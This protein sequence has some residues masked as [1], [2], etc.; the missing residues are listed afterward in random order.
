MRT[1]RGLSKAL[2]EE[3]PVLRSCHGLV[4]ALALVLSIAPCLSAQ[5]NP[6]WTEQK[7]EGYLPHMTV[8]EVQDLLT[9]TD[10]VIIPVASLE[11][12]GRHLP[13]GTDFL[14]GLERAKLIAARTDVLVAPILFP[15]QSPYHMGF[16]GTITLSAETVQRVYVEAAESLIRHGF[17]RL[18]FLNAHGGNQAITRFIVDRINQE[19]AGIAVELGAASAPFRPRTAATAPEEPRVF[20]RHGGVSET[21]RGLYLFPNLVDLASAR[22]AVL[23]LPRH[24]ERML[25]E[26]VAGDPAA[27]LVF[28]A[29]GLKAEETGKGTSAKEMST[30]GV[31]GVRDPREATAE[32]G[33]RETEA[34][35]EAA[36]RF[37]ERWKELRPMER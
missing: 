9:R 14:S 22:P 8:P 12:H 30:T 11:Q 31:W 24:M 32:Q 28:L 15:G 10:M 26:V 4:A 23:T 19:T 13:I 35:V 36:V 21:S 29:E 18:L 7:F 16:E 33:Q 34:F 37:I 20:D 2:K 3:T 27:E 17:K 5:A 1:V 6:L 25:P